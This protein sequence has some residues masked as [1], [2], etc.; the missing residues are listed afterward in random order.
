MILVDL[1][2]TIADDLSLLFDLNQQRPNL[3]YRVFQMSEPTVY[4]FLIATKIA[5][6]S[7]PKIREDSGIGVI[8]KEVRG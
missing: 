4:F 7:I 3:D 8:E 5:I 2:N 1:V 6:L